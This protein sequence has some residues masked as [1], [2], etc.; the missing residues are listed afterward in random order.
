MA[1]LPELSAAEQDA[2]DHARRVATLIRDAARALQTVHDQGIVHRDVKPAN[3]MLT[4]D[5][6]RVVLMDFGLA[7]GNTRTLEASRMAG[8][9]GT[10]RYAAPEQL[11]AAQVKVGPKADVRGLGVTLFELLTRHRLF[12]DAVDESQLTSWVLTKPVPRLCKIDPTLDPDLEAIVAAATELSQD[13]RLSAR[14]LADLLDLYLAGKPLPIRLPGM[15]EL[16]RRWVRD[17]K[18]L[19]GA[20]IAAAAAIVIGV[21]TGFALINA[22]K[23]RAQQAEKDLDSKNRDLLTANAELDISRRSLDVKNRDLTEATHRIERQ[24]ALS[25]I[26][27]GTNGLS[28]GD[29]YRGLAIL[30]QAYR[31]AHN[32]PDL[33]AS[34]RTL[35]GG[36]YWPGLQ[37]LHHSDPVYVVAFSPDG[38]KVLTGSWDNTARLWDVA[39]G[40]PLGEPLRHE[41]KVMAVAFSPDGTKV[42]TGS[43]DKTARLWD[44]ATG[45]P[46]GEPLRH[47]SQVQTVTFSPDGTKLLTQS[48]NIPAQ[49]WD[50]I[51]GKPLDIPIQYGAEVGAM[52]FSPD[53]NKLLTGSLDKTGAA[54]GCGHGQTSRRAAPA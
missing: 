1:P 23:N 45:K 44:A 46:L 14:Q 8:L 35:L 33:R 41:D 18:R 49:L 53:G 40:K 54:V 50:A 43:L 9:L 10:L 28:R 5:G 22:A 11:A 25:Y 20:I 42:L 17:H 7:K 32:D 3:L 48:R 21:T 39:T 38:T 12:E 27:R 24:L 4:P 13:D 51:T 19:V 6:T 26:E 36:W 16:L 31:A 29:K 47:H 2:G 52:A 34:V 30:G 15:V 37:R